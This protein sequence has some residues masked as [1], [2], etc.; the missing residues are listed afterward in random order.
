MLIDSEKFQNCEKE[1]LKVLQKY[2]NSTAE[3]KAML[4]NINVEMYSKIEL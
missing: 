3:A 4:S 1:V 2:T